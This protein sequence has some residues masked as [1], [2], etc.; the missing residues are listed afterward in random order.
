MARLSRITQKL[1]RT[2]VSTDDLTDALFAFQ[3]A[4]GISA[5]DV[6]GRVFA[7]GWDDEWPAASPERRHE[8]MEHY[9]GAE[10]SDA[11]R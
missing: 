9:I 5:G 6:A 4:V 3:N 2:A 7:F 1:V 8:M 10:R 11:A